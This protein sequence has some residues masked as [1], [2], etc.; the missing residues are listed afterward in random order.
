ML[1]GG[2]IKDKA[3]LDLYQYFYQFAVTVLLFLAVPAFIIKYF[4]GGDYSVFRTGFQYNKTAL[5]LCAVVYPLVIISIYFTS[6]QPVMQSEYPLS[7]LINTSWSV[8]IVYE[9]AYFFYFFSY[10]AFFRGYLQFGLKSENA[11]WREIVVILLIQTA[12]TTLFHIG[13]PT[14]E[15]TAAAVM[16]PVI[17]YVAIRFNSIGY[18]LGI[19]YLMNV[20][21]DYFILSHRH[22]LPAKF[23]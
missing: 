10:E 18:A 8:F 3:T 13:K 12:I 14:T 1:F 6:Q 11:G 4:L 2:L 7:K 9:I 15:I 23:F 16:G 20:F 21:M 5:L 19:H 22:I 17:G